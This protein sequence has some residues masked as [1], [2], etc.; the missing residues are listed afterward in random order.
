MDMHHHFFSKKTL[1]SFREVY[2]SEM[3]ENF[4]NSQPERWKKLSELQEPIIR[5]EKLIRN[6]KENEIDF[7]LPMAFG[8]DATGSFEVHEKFPDKFPGII[9]FLEP[10]THEDPE[11]I[12]DWVKKGACSIKLYPGRWKKYNILSPELLP[13][14]KKMVELNINPI[15]HVGVMKGGDISNLWPINPMQL[16]PWLV[17]KELKNLKFVIAHF[18]A[19]YLREVFR[20]A[21]SHRE[22]IYL[23]TSGSNDW[24]DWSP[25][26]N[27]TQVFEKSLKAL[28]ASNILFGTDSNFEMLRSDVILRQ[29]G[30]L[31]DLITKK[32]IT[33]E[34]REKILLKNSLELFNISI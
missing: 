20:I 15:I 4:K 3:E 32:V 2:G 22:R 8:F 34:D 30:I 9:P 12:E 33:P 26:I 23:D 25:W 11:I 6:M 16:K 1:E 29:K 19:G 17:N 7:I 5:A 10:D 28:K 14:F 31:R 27:L 24:I 21:Y 18:G 13:Y